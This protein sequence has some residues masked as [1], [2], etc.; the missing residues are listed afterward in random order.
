MLLAFKRAEESKAAEQLTYPNLLN[1]HPNDMNPESKG[2]VYVAR[3][4]D[5][6]FWRELADAELGSIQEADRAR[7]IALSNF[8]LLSHQLQ[9]GLH[10][11]RERFSQQFTEASIELYGSPE[12]KYVAALAANKLSEC[13]HYQGMTGVDQERVSRLTEFFT[14]QLGERKSDIDTAMSPETIDALDRFK[15]M[16]EDRYSDVFAVFE[17]AKDKEKVSP[18]EVAE[19]FNRCLEILADSNPAWQDWSAGVG[20]KRAMSANSHKKRISVG[21]IPRPGERLLPLVA[22]EMLVHA[23]RAVNGSASQDHI[24]GHGLPESL[25]A[26]EGLA[27]FMEIAISGD[28]TA[29]AVNDLYMNTGFALGLL[30]KA[31]ITRQEL[32]QVYVDMLVVQAQAEGRT[33]D[34]GDMTSKSWSHVNRIYRGSLGNEHIA[35]N[36]K[37]IAY[38]AGLMKITEFVQDRLRAGQAP[39][40]IFDYLVSARFDPANK[41]HVEYLKKVG[42][43]EEAP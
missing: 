41:Q 30:N 34:L 13:R 12:S 40:D 42:I 23:Q 25:D 32:Q 16:L 2:I 19:L 24:V 26:E 20:K 15:D 31:P 3:E 10:T 29:F 43:I 22:H 38:Y 35:V 6:A 39:A 33:I 8:V 4:R 36:T 21:S 14:G 37:D 27:K 18:E 5:G 28:R 1:M 7:A 11:S 17:S 9:D